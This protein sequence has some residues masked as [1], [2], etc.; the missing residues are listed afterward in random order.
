VQSPDGAQAQADALRQR[1][2]SLRWT[3]EELAARADVA[4]STVTNVEAGKSVSPKTIRKLTAAMA[5]ANS[6][7]ADDEVLSDILARLDRLE[8]QQRGSGGGTA[9]HDRRDQTA[10]S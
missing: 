2:E 9:D 10:D 5:A 7:P 8:R 4:R 3:Q 6:R 1:R